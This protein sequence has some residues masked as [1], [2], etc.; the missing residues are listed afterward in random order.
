MVVRLYLTTHTD[1][2]R[3]SNN[4]FLLTRAITEVSLLAVASMC[5]GVIMSM[6]PVPRLM[7]PNFLAYLLSIYLYTL[8]IVWGCVDGLCNFHDDILL[9]L[10]G[11]A[12]HLAGLLISI[13]LF[14]C[15][16]AARSSYAAVTD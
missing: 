2:N 15:N 7:W 9:H 11:V 1:I 12:W 8:C 4:S 6:S 3:H 5:S 14:R 16:T 13:R 10:G